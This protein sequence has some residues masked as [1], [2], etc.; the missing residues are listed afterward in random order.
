MD[1]LIWIAAT[2][3]L[4]LYGQLVM[5]WRADLHAA[6]AIGHGR[7][8]FLFAML[9]DPWVLSGLGGAF[10]ASIAY[11][12]VLERLPLSFAYPLM[13]LS[14]V[15]VPVAS[16]LVFGGKIPLVQAAGLALIVLGVSLS[17]LSK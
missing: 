12:F 11:M 10:L 17:A 8:E 15:L 6:K 14:F 4:G 13:A 5:K 16:V 2:L 9:T 7:P 1:H 3:T